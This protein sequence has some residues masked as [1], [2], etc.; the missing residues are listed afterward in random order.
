MSTSNRRFRDRRAGKD[1]RRNTQ[2]NNVWHE[3]AAMK[4]QWRDENPNSTPAEYDAA[5]HKILKQ[6]GI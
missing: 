5:I 3:Y 1:R 2:S 6:L 4:M